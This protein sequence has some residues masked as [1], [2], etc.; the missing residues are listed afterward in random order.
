MTHVQ[1]VLSIAALSMVVAGCASN[2]G[3]P[4][5][6]VS[7]EIELKA[8]ARYFKVDVVA[9]Y[10]KAAEK[11]AYR[12]EVVMGRIRAV[13]LQFVKFERQLNVERNTTQI[14]GDLAVLGLSGAG[15]TAGGAATK[16]ILSA[17]SGGVTGAKLSI[18]KTL[19]YEK[20]MPVLLHEMQA[21]RNTVLGEIRK[22]LLGELDAYPFLQALNDVDRYYEAGTVPGAMISI[23]S[24]AGQKNE[25]AK[26]ALKQIVEINYSV[27]QDSEALRAFWHPDGKVSDA[28]RRK[29]REAMKAVGLD[30]SVE[31][32]QLVADPRYT[33][34]RRRVVEILKEKQSIR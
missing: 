7:E 15:A 20:T 19:F 10:Q 11:K 9:E 31:I 13:D 30:E 21:S 17:I 27:N 28:N 12:Q 22:G 24:Q 4:E 18:D 14:G 6:M 5:R 34:Q 33:G 25:E 8:L 1:R 32:N 26:K 2:R 16:A 29:I 23:D 3:Y